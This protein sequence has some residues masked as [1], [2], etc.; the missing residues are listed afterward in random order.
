MKKIPF[1]IQ[2]PHDVLTLNNLFQRKGFRLFCVGGCVRD[3]IEHK[4]PKDF[5]LATNAKPDEIID[6]IKDTFKYNEIGKAF[7]IINVVSPTDT[8]EIATFRKDMS[9]GRRPDSV[10]FTD[11]ESDVMRRDL[12]INAL[13]YDIDNKQIIDLVGGI[14]DISN[15]RIRT[16]G[17]AVDRFGEDALR[18]L[19]TIRFAARMGSNLDQDII[20]SL[21]DNNSLTDVSPERIRDEFIKGITSAKSPVYFLTMLNN[22]KFFD[23]IFPNLTVDSNNFTDIKDSVISIANILKDNKIEGIIKTLQ[24]QKYTAN[25]IASILFLISFLSISPST[26]FKLKRMFN[27]SGLAVPQ[28]IQF[29]KLNDIDDKLVEAFIKTLQFNVSG[30]KLLQRGLKGQEIGKEIERLETEYFKANL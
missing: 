26:V 29:S 24:K 15:K 5:D 27:N 16:V 19:R 4:T 1:N 17:N 18:K 28:V 8:Y 14:D 25:E 2:L 11:I 22:F 21:S 20:Q 13:F 6:I 10:E 12:S 3:A 23:H 30:D 9:G 7:G